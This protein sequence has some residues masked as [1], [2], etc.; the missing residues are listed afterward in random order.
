V[1]LGL[2]KSS[3]LVFYKSIFFGKPFKIA[4]YVALGLVGSWTVAFFFANL[5]TCWPVSPFIE[6][7]YKNNCIDGLSMWYAM[8][9]SDTIID[10]LILF[11]PIPVV[12]KLQLPLRQKIG[13]LVM[14]LLG[15]T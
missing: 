13:V 9:I 7:F 15:A 10:F 5:F 14:F 3:I 2:V 8:A 4:S 12:L 1:G 6:P 11:L